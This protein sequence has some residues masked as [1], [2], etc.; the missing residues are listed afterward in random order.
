L[1]GNPSCVCG[2]VF[3]E[4]KQGYTEDQIGYLIELAR[5][6]APPGSTVR[7]LHPIMDGI[8]SA[9]ETTLGKICTANLCDD[10]RCDCMN[11]VLATF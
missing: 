8:S 6:I 5:D 1:I 2:H 9:V 10:S 7:D 11:F 3:S 4:H